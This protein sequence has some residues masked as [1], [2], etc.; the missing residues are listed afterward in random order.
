MK[1]SFQIGIVALVAFAMGIFLASPELRAFAA[2]MIDST[3]I[4]DGSILSVDIRNGEIRGPD[5]AGNSVTSGK[6]KDGEVKVADIGADAVGASELIGVSRL[7]FAECLFEDDV[8]RA[9]EEWY[10][11]T[12]E[13]PGTVSGD[14]VVVSRTTDFNCYDINGA[15]T[16][17]G[18]VHIKG[19]NDCSTSAALGKTWFS[20][21]VFA[22]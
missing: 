1:H 8:S 2:A 13:V 22:K 18:H 15:Y 10:D 14:R 12:C 19:R 11:V 7:L 16:T 3:D 17:D 4:V 6:I 9:P 21:I 20:I 5:L